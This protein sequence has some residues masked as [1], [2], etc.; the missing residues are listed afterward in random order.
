MKRTKKIKLETTFAD[1]VLH[2]LDDF[3]K[4]VERGEV[5]TIRTVKLEL[6]PG[7]YTSERIRELRS[8]LG[9]SQAIFAQLV[10]VSVD[11]V[12][13]WEHGQRIPQPVH[14]RLL[15]DIDSDPKAWM[16]RVIR[17]AQARPAR[18]RDNR[19]AG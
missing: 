7:V 17:G 10:A 3:F 16:K 6:E 15:D 13:K 4:A 18:S 8:R 11:L 9:V 19:L 12:Q 14:R 1:E 5:V 2:G